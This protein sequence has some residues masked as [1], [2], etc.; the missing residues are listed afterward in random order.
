[1]LNV[2][3]SWSKER[4][5]MLA[6]ELT[7]WLPSVLQATRPWMSSENIA[8]G[9]RW[10]TQ[11]GKNLEKHDVGILCV[12]PENHQSPWLLFEAG[13]L[14]KTLG[15][16][17]VCPLLLAIGPNELDGPL[18]QFQ[19]TI[20]ERN[21]ILR[22][23]ESLNQLLG[24]ESI[25]SEV[26]RN[27]FDA[28]WPILESRVKEVVKI[29]I[30]ATCRALA[31]VISALSKVGLPE[32]NIANQAYFESGFESHTLYTTAT[33]IAQDRLYIFG[34]KNRKIFDKEHLDFIN[35]LSQRISNGFD[36]RVLFLDTCANEHVLTC[37][38][39]DDDFPEQ[40]QTCH[41]NAKS[42]L[43]NAGINPSDVCRK[44][45]FQ[46]TVSML[47]VD[48][49][50]LYSPIKLNECGRVQTLTKSAF[51][52]TSATSEFGASLVELF[53]SHWENSTPM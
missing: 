24:D 46:R 31:D 25:S 50:V 52:A 1:M 2:F 8:K 26:L 48:D 4:S 42:I 34:R 17:R 47:V 33:S 16:S 12:T 7:K 10:A 44:Y 15:V 5:R 41:I 32:P 36:L 13:A 29:K 35:S 28:K 6:K 37:A 30:P 11:V 9:D 43:K 27:E 45:D 39:Q 49:A 14:S 53:L 21:D 3:V 38:H 19:A 20:F 51:N 23:V 40:L 22:L 18:T